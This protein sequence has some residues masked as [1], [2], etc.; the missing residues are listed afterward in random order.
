MMLGFASLP[1]EQTAA[2]NG[3]SEYDPTYPVLCQHRSVSWLFFHVRYRPV[4]SF[5]IVPN[6]SCRSFTA[7]MT[8]SSS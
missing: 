4:E 3:I 6:G 8:G 1:I 5:I 7:S 2:L